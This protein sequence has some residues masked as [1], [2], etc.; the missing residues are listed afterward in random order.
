MAKEGSMPAGRLVTFTFLA[1]PLAVQ[2]AAAQSGNMR[3]ADLDRNNDGVV[4]R[5]EWRG[6]RESFVVQDWNGDGVLSGAEV[7]G[8]GAADRSFGQA[9]QD[10]EFTA[11]DANGNGRVERREWDGSVQ[12][13]RRLD[14]NGDNTLTR[15]EMTAGRQVAPA[16]AQP[17]GERF[18]D[19]DADGDGR[20]T[21]SEWPGTRRGF[22]LQD[23]NRDGVI[24][25]REYREASGVAGGT[26]G[27]A[28][29]S[30]QIVRMNLKEAWT[31]TGLMVNAGDLISFE[32]E[33]SATLSTTDAT[34]VASPAGARSGR[35]AAEAPL[36]DQPAGALIA[37]IGDST[38]FFVGERRELRAPVSGR[39]FLGIND[40]HLPDNSGEYR[41]NVLVRTR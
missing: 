8:D 11:L 17:R 23:T 4:T 16:G 36:R 14:R 13:F 10:D 19:F 1:L 18:V 22:E 32:A 21:T 2:F 38:P 12:A 31:D 35:R 7:R 28:G 39:I 41:V 30:G 25:R 24:T 27:A 9:S 26:P 37:R 34:D 33:G 5:D 6:S 3:F 20:I 29:T 15:A 40:D